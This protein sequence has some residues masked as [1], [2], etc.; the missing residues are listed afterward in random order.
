[1]PEKACRYMFA[2]SV[3]GKAK[4][5]VDGNEAIDLWDTQP[6]KVEETLALIKF[7]MERYTEMEVEQGR[8]YELEIV[9]SEIFPAIRTTIHEYIPVEI[10]CSV[11]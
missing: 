1:M 8:E 3:C 7:S 4:M 11:K 5:F 9:I 10:D 2:L 6:P